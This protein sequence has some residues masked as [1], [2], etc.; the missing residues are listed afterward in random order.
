MSFTSISSLPPEM[1]MKILRCFNYRDLAK[2]RLVSRNWRDLIV[3]GRILSN[4]YGKYVFFCDYFKR[5]KD[6]TSLDFAVLPTVDMTWPMWPYLTL[7]GHECFRPRPAIFDMKINKMCP[8]LA[9]GKN[10]LISGH[11]WSILGPFWANFTFQSQIH[12]FLQKEEK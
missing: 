5:Q 12:K 10:L 1:L 11:L 4:R 6:F 3:K 9:F 2:F 8:Y 7:P